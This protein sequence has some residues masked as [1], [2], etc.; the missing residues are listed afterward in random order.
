LQPKV[1]VMLLFSVAMGIVGQLF[2]KAGMR[3]T[4][5][6]E[7]SPSVVLLFFRPKVFVGLCC[8]G[9]ATTTW[10]VVLSK[11]PLS[12]AY[13]FLAVGYIVIVLMGK[14]VFREEVVMAT[15]IGVLLICVGVVLIGYGS[16]ITRQTP[17]P[18]V[19]KSPVAVAAH[20]PPE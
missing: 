19:E 18:A 3:E 2:F 8:Y 16:Q 7:L 1:I 12:L 4:G 13:P 9:I 10:L 14:F 11:A 20:F 15:W 6:I 17:L 5:N